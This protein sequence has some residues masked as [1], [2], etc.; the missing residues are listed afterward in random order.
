M[1]PSRQFHCRTAARFDRAIESDV[2]DPTCLFMDAGRGCCKVRFVGSQREHRGEPGDSRNESDDKLFPIRQW[3]PWR[4]LRLVGP[5]FQRDW[6]WH[7][8]DSRG[9]QYRRQA[10]S[11]RSD[12]Y[13]QFSESY[14]PMVNG[15]RRREIRLVGQPIEWHPTDRARNRTHKLELY[16]ARDTS[17][18]Y[19]S[20]LGPRDF[21]YRLGQCLEHTNGFHNQLSRPA[22]GYRSRSFVA[23]IGIVR[24]RFIR[25]CLL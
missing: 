22:S 8:V 18:R 17:I 19:V 13:R 2:C 14:L 7:V 4:K 20:I 10:D 1:E 12:W 25:T 5:S 24:H 11:H 3:S 21:Q 15:S 9:I 6:T 23:S 16:P